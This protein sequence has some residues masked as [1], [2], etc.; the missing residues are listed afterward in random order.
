[1]V[2]SNTPNLDLALEAWANIKDNLLLSDAP[3]QEL[4]ALKDRIKELEAKHEAS[5]PL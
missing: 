5:R 2:S 1:M 4:R 3:F